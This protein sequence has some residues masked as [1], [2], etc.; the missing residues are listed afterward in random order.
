MRGVYDGGKI[1]FFYWNITLNL[2]TKPPEKKLPLKLDWLLSLLNS[3]DEEGYT[4]KNFWYT[5]P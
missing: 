1:T 5:F 4:I 2:G 3:A